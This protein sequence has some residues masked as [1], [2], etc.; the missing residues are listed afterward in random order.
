MRS[1]KLVLQVCRLFIIRRIS[2]LILIIRFRL[3]SFLG[4]LLSL[5]PSAWLAVI[6]P[7]I[8]V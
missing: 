2:A 5:E 4:V 8:T 3:C 1:R 6:I 7:V